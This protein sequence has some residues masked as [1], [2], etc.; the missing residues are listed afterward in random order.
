MS[1]RAA[2]VSIQALSPALCADLVALSN[3]FRRSST[4]AVC[5]GAVCEEA[6]SP[7]RK[8]TAGRNAHTLRDDF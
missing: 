1:T 4:V 5:G 7:E 2:L 3:A 6:T 8:K